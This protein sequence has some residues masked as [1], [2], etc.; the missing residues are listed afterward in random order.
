MQLA[1]HP[2]N[3]E[4]WL[5]NPLPRSQ[6]HTKNKPPNQEQRCRAPG[7]ELGTRLPAPRAAA[8]GQPSCCVNYRKI[9]EDTVQDSFSPFSA[10]DILHFLALI[11]LL[12][13]SPGAPDILLSLKNLKQELPLFPL[14]LVGI[15]RQR[16]RR[17]RAGAHDG[18]RSRAAAAHARLLN[19]A[20]QSSFPASSRVSFAP[21][22]GRIYDSRILL[23]SHSLTST[24]AVGVLYKT[25]WPGVLLLPEERRKS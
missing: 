11:H 25:Q 17:C 6:L 12:S 10:D 15:C 9:N 23:C 8:P 22:L 1:E 2:V 19:I 21:R 18:V 5:T 4:H 20:C 13:A 3:S 16:G 14:Q 7:R 24:Q